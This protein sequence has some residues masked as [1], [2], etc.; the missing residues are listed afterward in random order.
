ML[1]LHFPVPRQV[2]CSRVGHIFRDFHPYSFPNNKDTHGINTARLAHVWMD[3]YKRFFFMHQPGL[4]NNPIV[5]DLTHRKQLRQKLRCKSFKWYLDNV[6]PE[7]FV[8]DENVFGYGQVRT[9]FEMCLDDLQLAED[10]VGPLGLYQCHPYLAMSQ[11]FSISRK[12]ELRKENFCAEVFNERDVQL[13]ECH[14]HKREQYWVLHRNGTIFSPSTNKCL[15]S[16]GVDS[17][18]G[19]R[20][21]NCRNNVYQ[22]WKF[23]HVNMTAVVV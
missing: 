14:G 13:T 6:Y 22:R 5:G 1:G 21:H 23:D 19:L 11:Y 17:G 9:E 8:L 20:V 15:S 10:K 18:K 16:E 2:P 4:E 3:D 7:K 12:G